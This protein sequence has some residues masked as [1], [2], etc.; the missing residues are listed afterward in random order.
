MEKKEILFRSATALLLAGLIAVPFPAF[1]ETDAAETQEV[2]EENAEI[3]TSDTEEEP[4]VP[5]NLTE[6]DIPESVSE[7]NGN[8]SDIVEE[9]T[10]T[11]IENVPEDEE[12][13]EYTVR[14][15]AAERKLTVGEFT[16]LDVIVT[17][18]DAEL[19]WSSS[20]E[21]V[22]TVDEDGIVTANAEGSATITAATKKYPSVYDEVV[23][24][25]IP[26]EAEGIDLSDLLNNTTDG[27]LTIKEDVIVSGS[28]TIPGNVELYVEGGSLTV[29]P[30]ST[31]S[32]LGYCEISDGVLAVSAD[33]EF[34]NAG[35]MVAAKC[36]RISVDK[37]GAYIHQDGAV[38]IL[39]QSESQEAAVEGISH[40]YIEL[41]VFASTHAQLAQAMNESSYSFVTIL[42]PSIDFVS[43]AGVASVT[44]AKCISL[45]S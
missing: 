44:G 14:L 26:E 30:G 31:L 16:C 23:L 36:G 10:E 45:M 37:N 25:V 21:S 18:E 4:E 29:L 40:S 27:K 8:I 19:V 11:V 20:D 32:L 5:E 28:V 9:K 15:S 12:T 1:A 34:S 41:T 33:A 6:E 42:V 39:D 35:F 7:G 17:P 38:V 2:Y 24:E 3:L 43:E 22:M 13:V